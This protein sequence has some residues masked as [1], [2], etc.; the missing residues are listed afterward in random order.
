MKRAFAFSFLPDRDERLFGKPA[1][2]RAA[3]AHA[4]AH[5]AFHRISLPLLQNIRLIERRNEAES[6]FPRSIAYHLGYYKLCA[7]GQ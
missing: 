5:G 4:L 2:V 7:A 6:R 3:D 1:L